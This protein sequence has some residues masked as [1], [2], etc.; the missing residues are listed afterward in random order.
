MSNRN[1]KQTLEAKKN[2][3]KNNQLLLNLLK[4]TR[5]KEELCD[6]LGKGNRAVRTLIAECSMYFAVISYSKSAGYRLAKPISELNTIEELENELQE[7][8][9][10]ANEIESRKKMLSK[11]QK[12]LIANIKVI[13]KK[14]KEA[15]GE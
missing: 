8:Q 12:H 5:T 11:R 7:L 9:S 15:K 13:Q 6:L 14:L 10:V 1:I 3:A 2:F 4:E